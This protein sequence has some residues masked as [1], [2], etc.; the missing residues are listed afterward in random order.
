[1]H[2]RQ[3]GQHYNERST[4]QILENSMKTIITAI[5]MVLACTNAAADELVTLICAFK[6]GQIEVAVNYTRETVNDASAVITDKEIYWTP[7]N[8]KDGFA[9][10]N[11]YSGIMQMS[12]GPVEYVGMCNRMPGK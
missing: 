1:M 11:R 8:M 7:E 4:L 12:A 9:V 5:A 2:C 6:H 3:T 10:I